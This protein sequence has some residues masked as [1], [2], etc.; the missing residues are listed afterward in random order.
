MD[1]VQQDAFGRTLR[2][3]LFQAAFFAGALDEVS[4]FKIVFK[5]KIFFCHFHSL[6]RKNKIASLSQGWRYHKLKKIYAVL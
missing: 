4:D 3:G 6:T 5:F 2:E 1:L